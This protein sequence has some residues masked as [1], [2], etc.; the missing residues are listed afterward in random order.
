MGQMGAKVGRGPPLVTAA[1]ALRCRNAQDDSLL[2]CWGS[3][4]VGSA[5]A[6]VPPPHLPMPNITTTYSG[7]RLEMKM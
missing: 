5:S 6:L 3:S 7:M 1:A 4:S 2:L